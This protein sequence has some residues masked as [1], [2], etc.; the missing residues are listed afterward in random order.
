M[1]NR[2]YTDNT[3]RALSKQTSYP[4]VFVNAELIGG[5]DELETWLAESERK[6]AA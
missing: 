2:D 6:D 1:L 5:A 3:L 4:Q